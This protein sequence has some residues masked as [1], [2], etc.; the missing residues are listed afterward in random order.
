MNYIFKQNPVLFLTRLLVPYLLTVL[1]VVIATAILTFVRAAIN[2]STVALLYLL[3]VGF[4]TA[5]WGLGPGA[6][7][8]FLSF[9]TFNYFFIPP[10]YTLMV[11]HNQDFLTLV[12]FL[13]IAA[14][15]S[16]MVGR[17]RQSLAEA[18]ARER[19]AIRLYELSTVLAGLHEDREIVQTIAEHTMETFQASQVDVVVE[20][21]V[22]WKPIVVSLRGDQSQFLLNDQA[23]SDHP[24]LLVPLQT[25]RGL[26]G[27]IRLWRDKPPI[28]PADER[29]LRT[30]ASQG[31]LALERSRLSQAETRAHILEESDRLKSSLLSSVSHEL[32]SP[33]ATIKA[34]VTSLRSETVEWDSEARKEL[35][36]AV[37]EETDHL[38]HLVGNL[39]NMSRIEAGALKPKREW[40]SLAEIAAIVL[41]RMRQRSSAE[42]V[43]QHVIEVDISEDLPLVPVDFVQMEQVFTNLISNSLKYSPENTTIRIL[44]RVLDERT[45]LVQVTNQGPPV[46]EEHLDRIFDKFYRITAAERVTGTGLGLSICKGIV[47]AHGGRIWGENL[48]G[49]FAFNFTLPLYWEGEPNRA[50][51]PQVPVE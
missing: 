11:R 47:E 37:E 15:I 28:T 48:P 22:K 16:Q 41:H 50:S 6:L 1:F 24:D 23:D 13:G 42:M 49:G 44:A 14:V 34:A 51:R 43:Q 2:P 19:D 26:L 30:F 35:L 9:L 12:I 27:E 21:D 39:L 7:A 5:F 29:L 45:M 32:R 36:A 25:A 33:L 38:N 8:A 17:T 3:P 20:G 10:Y 46:P 4:S 18:T 40:N 31:V